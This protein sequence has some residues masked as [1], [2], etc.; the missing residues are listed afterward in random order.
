MAKKTGETYQV[1]A[2]K[3]RPGTFEE[4]IGQDAMVRILRNA[5]AD[6]RISQAYILTGVR[7]VGKTTT[8]RIIAKG[9][10]CTADG[11]DRAVEPCGQCESCVSVAEGRHMDVLELDAASRSQVS[12]MREILE[13]VTF[14]PTLG[15]YKVYLIDEIH[16]L[17]THAFNALLKTLEEPPEHVKFIF[18][19]T[20]IRK[21]PVTVLSRCQR[22][23]LKRIDPPVMRRH[24]QSI[25]EREKIPITS[26]AVELITRAAEGSVRDAVSLLDQAVGQ[27]GKEIGPAAVR[28]MLGLADRGRTIDLL[29]L[30]M[31]GEAAA[32]L[33]E[34]NSQYSEGADPHAV[35]RD[36]AEAVHLISILKVSPDTGRDVEL[37]PDESKRGLELAERL[38][39][40]ALSRAWQML[41]KA[42]EEAPNSPSPL[43]AAEM[44]VIRLCYVQELPPAAQLL[45]KLTGGESAQDAN[46]GRN[47]AIASAEKP[48]KVSNRAGR[49]K[50]LQPPTE[51]KES[52]VHSTPALKSP[53][54]V[55][56]L[57]K[58]GG[59]P[60]LAADFEKFANEVQIKPGI[61]ALN[62]ESGAPDRFLETLRTSVNRLT[63][64]DWKIE[65]LPPSEPNAGS[66]EKAS[67]KSERQRQLL[68][69]ER[70]KLSQ[71]VLEAFPG[72][73][74]HVVPQQSQSDPT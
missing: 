30:I 49:D 44:A 21:V 67:S 38:P 24:L 14:E 62:L 25:A 7:G 5:F 31:K 3:Y 73:T 37:P 9:L 27:G 40:G 33:K 42:A 39:M 69:A 1:L 45:Q 26:E 63:G 68:E 4:L 11:A 54:D 47:A 50:T 55:L 10:N 28:E 34:L 12:E 60:R 32:A 8:A 64:Q 71:S 29:E 13:N 43:M 72:S 35:L 2:R 53:G 57:L 66:R 18:A 16:M 41:L 65:Q 17:S 51:D 20:E 74:V 23:D 36:L 52:R 70:H 59:Q 61:I 58:S 19:T 15:R 46:A 6:G 22:F 56:A 48:N